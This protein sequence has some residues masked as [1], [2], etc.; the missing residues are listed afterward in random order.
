MTESGADSGRRVAGRVAESL[1]NALYR[2]ALDG[3]SSVVAHV[4]G[5]LRQVIPRLIPGDRVE[6][7]VSPYDVARGR[8]VS[9]ARRAGPEARASDGQDGER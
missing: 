1:P 6:V 9:R 4:E 5:G 3:G 7:V 2:V 8:I